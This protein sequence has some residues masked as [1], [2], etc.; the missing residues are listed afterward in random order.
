MLLFPHLLQKWLLSR[1]TLNVADEGRSALFLYLYTKFILLYYIFVTTSH[2]CLLKKKKKKGHLISLEH[3]N[4][5]LE[6]QCIIQAGQSGTK[7]GNKNLKQSNFKVDY[8]SNGGGNVC[9][10]LPTVLW[11]HKH[12]QDEWTLAFSPFFSTGCSTAAS[13]SS[14]SSFRTCCRTMFTAE[15]CREDFQNK[16]SYNGTIKNC[17][18]KMV[19]G[20]LI[21]VDIHIIIVT[22]FY[23]HLYNKIKW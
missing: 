12:C 9:W 4:Q 22:F 14:I 15:K 10:H 5:R 21:G 16:S 18:N 13:L 3:C 20:V 17:D 2:S 11:C 7:W 1:L 23:T 8:L 19:N 6:T